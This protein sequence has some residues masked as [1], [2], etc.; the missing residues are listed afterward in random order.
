MYL[1]DV[2]SIVT[3]KTMS[4]YESHGMIDDAV[5][6]EVVGDRVVVVDVVVVVVFSALDIVDNVVDEIVN[7]FTLVVVL[8]VDVVAG[9]VDDGVLVEDTI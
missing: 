8:L 9:V 6:Q 5:E 2:E 1:N 3:S 7:G 4:I